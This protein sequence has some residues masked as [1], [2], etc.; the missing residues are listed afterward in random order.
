DFFMTIIML[1]MIEWDLNHALF[2]SRIEKIYGLLLDLQ[3]E[4]VRSEYPAD[5]MSF[6]ENEKYLNPSQLKAELSDFAGFYFEDTFKLEIPLADRSDLNIDPQ[7]SFNKNF[8]LLIENLSH[9]NA[10]GY[11]IFL[12]T[13][14]E[15]QSRR[16][17]SIFHDREAG[18]PVQT[19]L[20]SLHEGFIDHQ[21]K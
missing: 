4:K 20:S 7:P 9:H 8:T 11:D 16:L 12:F 17:N 6:F 10:S 13:E 15:R 5:V 2:D 1:E 21:L 19:I 14:S 18:L 3:K